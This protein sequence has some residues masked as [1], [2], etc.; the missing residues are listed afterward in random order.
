MSTI[1]SQKTGWLSA[2]AGVAIL[3]AV[4]PPEFALEA[5][6]DP[7][8]DNP[9][10]NEVIADATRPAIEIPAELASPAAATSRPKR[11]TH[12]PRGASS[13]APS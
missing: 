7:A 8:D 10:I 6:P 1:G 12:G 13:Q 11:C 9:K 4:F 2:L 3:L 5:A